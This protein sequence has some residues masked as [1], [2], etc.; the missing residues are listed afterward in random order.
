[1]SDAALDSILSAFEIEELKKGAFFLQAGKLCRKMAFIDSGYLRMYD[2]ANGKEITLWIASQGKFITSLSSFVF[3]SENYWNIQA[4]TDCTLYTINRDKHF[5]LCKQEPKWLEFDNL[6]LARSFALLE[7]SMFNQL[8][9]TAE[10]RLKKLLQDEPAL[11]NHVPLQHIASM[12]G[13][14]P[15]SLSRLRKNIA[16]TTS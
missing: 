14:A 11:F 5:E 8:H 15:E 2:I 7:Q 12:L 9:T 10:Q 4:E 1:M 6:L 3:E 13:I 16:H